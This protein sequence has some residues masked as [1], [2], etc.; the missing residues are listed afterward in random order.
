M[1]I[2]LLC[3][4]LFGCA[5]PLLGQQAAPAP[6]KTPLPPGPLL[7]RTP[8]YSSWSVTSQGT[9]LAGGAHATSATDGGS[10]GQ[11]K[12]A[13]VTQL[14][15]VKTGL[16]ILEYYVDATG[17]RHE[18]WHVAGLRIMLHLAGAAKPLICPEYG[19]GD[20]DSIDFAVS[21]FAGLDWVSAKTYSG[22]ANYQGRDCIVFKSSVSPLDAEAQKME[23]ITIKG[24][25]G[26]GYNPPPPVKVPAMAYIDLDTRLP[27]VVQFGGEKRTYQYGLAPRALLQLPAQLA[28]PA[29]EYEH[30]I[31]ALSAPA[32][33]PF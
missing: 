5:A 28:G 1:K 25:K 15:V 2:R 14:T 21:D 13:V 4:F 30:R 17:Q 3:F 20:I 7:K 24:A 32:S 18:I 23:A 16:R 11:K 12:E 31:E 26:Y 6:S 10:Q 9:P 29:E 27:L 33:R 22:V 8:D 19:G